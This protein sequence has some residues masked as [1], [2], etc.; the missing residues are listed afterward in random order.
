M[1]DNSN[2]EVQ[3]IKESLG[4]N[5]I[6]GAL[7]QLE[8]LIDKSGKKKFKK[9]YILLSSKY[10][11]LRERKTSGLKFEAYEESE[12]I[13]SVLELINLVSEK[14]NLTPIINKKSNNSTSKKRGLGNWSQ[15]ILA[16]CA[17]ITLTLGILKT[18]PINPES[19]SLKLL[20]E[21][22]LT[23]FALVG[24]SM[25]MFLWMLRSYLL[26]KPQQKTK[27]ILEDF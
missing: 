11:N 7:F 25:V 3:I 13:N 15:I 8:K 4:K 17:L 10:N 22:A 27:E 21:V 2:I 20:L 23:P 1:K 24:Y 26:R 12:I 6:E 19:S 14:S 16:T 5:D 9:H 18:N